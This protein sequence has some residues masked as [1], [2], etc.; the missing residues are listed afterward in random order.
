[1]F[2]EEKELV[3]QT[4]NVEEPATEELVDGMTDP[5]EV[6]ETE[7][8]TVETF[9]RE[10]VDEIIAKKLGRKEAKMR[11]EY[12]KRMAE[13]EEAELVL[14]AGL[15]TSNITEATGQLRDFYAKKGVTIPERAIPQYSNDDLQVL[16]ANEAQKIIDSGI[17][18]VIEEANRLADIGLDN[19]SPREKILFSHLAEYSKTEKEK[20]EL[21]QIGVKPEALEDSDF[22]DFQKNLNP[23]M[24]VKDQ[25]EMYLKFKPKAQIEPIGSMKGIK[26]E[27]PAVKDFY[28]FEE[29]QK[30]TQADFDKNPA[31]FEAVTKS[32]TKW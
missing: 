4:E 6:T 13:L 14:N 8:E 30:F 19:M 11:R 31:L 10:Q 17:E 32:M 23:K 22:K 2:T 9:T 16:A 1:M 26:T 24:S 5:G 20:K 21:A 27:E 7:E 18:E 12:E 15:G 25:Y 29:A 3:E 28:S